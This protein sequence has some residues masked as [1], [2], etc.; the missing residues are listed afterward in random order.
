SN[1]F[2]ADRHVL[3]SPQL[4]ASPGFEGVVGGLGVGAGVV[5]QTVSFATPVPRTPL[6]PRSTRLVVP[7]DLTSDLTY[8]GTHFDST[9]KS[10]ARSRPA[11][12]APASASANPVP[13]A[14]YAVGAL[15]N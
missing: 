3:K 7:N 9:T 1:Q 15:V 10:G 2:W 5:L 13:T 4:T 14:K 8:D 11:R 6:P 12:A